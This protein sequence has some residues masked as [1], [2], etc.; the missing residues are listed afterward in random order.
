MVIDERVPI[1]ISATETFATQLPDAPATLGCL[2]LKHRK[3]ETS[4]KGEDNSFEGFCWL[5]NVLY[6]AEG[7]LQ[8]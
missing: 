3:P 1:P 2:G 4:T 8:G 5:Q 7:S 6:R